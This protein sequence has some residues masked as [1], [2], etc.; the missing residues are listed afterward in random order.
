[1]ASENGTPKDPI[2]HK[3]TEEDENAESRSVIL[4]LLK[5]VKHEYNKHE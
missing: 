2:P 4:H 3:Q 5:Q 1:L